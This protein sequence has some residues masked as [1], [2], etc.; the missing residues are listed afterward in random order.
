MSA[1]RTPPQNGIVKR[2][3]RSIIDCSRT[4]MMEKSTLQKYWREVVSTIVYTLNW[5][6]VKKGTNKTHFE[7]SYGYAPNTNYFKVFGR[8]CYILKD[9]R[10]WKLDAKINEG[11]FLGYPTKRKAYK[12]L[13]YNTNKIVESTNV[14]VDEFVE[15][16]E[17]E[18]EK[19]PKDY[20][21][22]TLTKPKM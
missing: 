13:N 12:C 20:K 16:N 4:T 8:K 10:K 15:N 22:C 14:R 18:C 7:L 6:Q 21:I 11:I 1:P 2:R 19:E 5:V 9:A 17:E 3:N